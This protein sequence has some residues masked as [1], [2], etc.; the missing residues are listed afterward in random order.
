[1]NINGINLHSHLEG[2]CPIGSLGGMRRQSGMGDLNLDVE[3]NN[4]IDFSKI[5]G[6]CSR[7]F[8]KVEDFEFGTKEMLINQHKFGI[9]YSEFRISP[10]FHVFEGNKD[11]S[12]IIKMVKNGIRQ[13]K[14]QCGIEARFIIDSARHYG[15][16]HAFT[17]FHWV[18]DYFDPNYLVGFG[19]GGVEVSSDLRSFE[20]LFDEASAFKIPLSVH[21]GEVHEN[22][23]DNLLY[24]LDY[25]CV[26]G[27]GHG[28]SVKDLNDEQKVRFS[29]TRKAVEVCLSSNI[30][31]RFV[32]QALEHPISYLYENSIPFVLG[33]DDET[34]FR[35]DFQQECR[36]A[37]AI[38][39]VKES[40]IHKINLEAIEYAFCDQKTKFAIRNTLTQTIC[41]EE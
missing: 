24:T 41:L 37:Q 3:I 25:E 9:M 31:M 18:A 11:I 16:D 29:S 26:G 14:E 40:V 15:L 32:N 35:T 36:K 19:I 38:L 8:C 10:Y 20:K 39:N 30:V 12:N 22:N 13:A 33:T 34:I 23:T 6:Q 21:I 7:S 27:I 1:M 5:F 4:L 28:L 17:N 2:S